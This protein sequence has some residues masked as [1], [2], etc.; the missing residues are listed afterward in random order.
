MNVDVETQDPLNVNVSLEVPAAENIC[1]TQ[2]Q[3]KPDKSVTEVKK[4]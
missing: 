4:K 2:D 3:V 1:S